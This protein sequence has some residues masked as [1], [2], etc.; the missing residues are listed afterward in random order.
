MIIG[1]GI[2]IAD[3]VRIRDSLDKYGDKFLQRIFTE[4]EIALCQRYR[5][6]VE[7]YAGKFAVFE[8]L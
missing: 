6:P 3:Q 4:Q 8:R 1:L 7:H 5:Y 2:D